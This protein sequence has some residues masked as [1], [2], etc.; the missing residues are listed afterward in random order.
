MSDA[1]EIKRQLDLIQVVSETVDLDTRSR[2]PKAACPFHVERTPSFVIFPDTQ[3]WRCF[4]ACATGGDVFAF[5]MKRDGLSF[6]EALQEG[7]RRV[8]LDLPSPRQPT[9]DGDSPLY[10]A[11][12]T[13]L[14]YFWSMLRSH[15]GEEAREYLA[16]RGIDVEA[17]RRRDIGLAPSGLDS[18][19][20]HLK[21]VGVRAAAAKDAGLVVQNRDGTWRD[22]FARRVTVAIRDR[23]GRVIGF[24]GRSLDGS[25]PK[26]LNTPRTRLFDKSAVLYGLNWAEEAVRKTGQAVVVEGYMDTITAHEHGYKNVVASMG[27]A[28]TAEQVSQIVDLAKTVILALDADA[29]G[30]E[31][32]LNS[33][34]SVWSIH[35]SDGSRRRRGPEIKIAHLSEGKDPD[36]A[37]RHA[38]EE[39]RAA[40]EDAVPLLEWLI[41]AYGQRHDPSTPEGKLS[42]V[43]A[44][45]ALIKGL[46][47]PYEQDRY[48]TRL[49]EILG[50]TYE[51][52]R[53]YLT[54]SPRGDRPRRRQ[55][56]S[57]PAIEGGSL[58]L[59][60][61]QTALEE[62]TLAL[63]L[64][65]PDLWEYSVDLPEHVFAEPANRA[66]FGA[67]KEFGRIEGLTDTLDTALSER[68]DQLVERPLPPSDQRTRIADVTECIRR[69]HEKYLRML[70][71][72]EQRVLSELD[73]GE[74][75]E[76][77]RAQ[78]QEQ[79]LETN[80]RLKQL[81]ARPQ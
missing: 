4:G 25:E 50:L 38:P 60:N 26:Y 58:L 53:A 16:G 5:L 64:Q 11:N 65:H 21:S 39:W 10:S 55:R 57:E 19:A 71:T 74:V 69:L 22:M 59:E 72:Q 6:R 79:S 3:V 63:V 56:P 32:T 33:L 18:L 48:I 51:Q 61:T 12:E 1:D 41:E 37:I 36:E 9:E 15:S 80:Q 28:I 77:V 45:D 42:I 20:G 46:D 70:K 73:Q 17:A 47:N 54:H 27:T 29:A 23:R 66:L 34:E 43:N 81:F 8:G 30:Q 2:T 31:A 78:I 67:M 76:E 13:A 7:A 49:S 75:S 52:V 24:G 14:D 68:V 35:S 40:L 44:V 62:H